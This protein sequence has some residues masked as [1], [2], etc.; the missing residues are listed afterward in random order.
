[1]FWY[2]IGQIS[3]MYYECQQVQYGGYPMKWLRKII[4]K[5]MHCSNV[6]F[7]VLWAILIINFTNKYFLFL[8]YSAS[9]ISY[10][11]WLNKYIIM[12][13]IILFIGQNNKNANC[14]TV[15][16][17]QYILS[18]YHFFPINNIIFRITIYLFKKISKRCHLHYKTKIRNTN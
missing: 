9:G 12:L 4:L 6:G 13:Q 18:Q 11:F 15:Y 17:I 10:L 14:L 2:T 3:K 1:M 7:W 16:H 8:F 5:I